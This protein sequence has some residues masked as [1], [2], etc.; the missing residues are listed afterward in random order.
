MAS[1]MLLGVTSMNR[2]L[3]SLLVMM[4]VLTLA[5]VQACLTS[6]ASDNGGELNPQPLPPGPEERENGDS[7]GAV[8]GSSSSGGTSPPAPQDPGDAGDGGSDAPEGG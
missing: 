2:W 8:G 5:G 4:G 1:A 3:K 7:T 6:S